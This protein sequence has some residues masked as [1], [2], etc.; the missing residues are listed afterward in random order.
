MKADVLALLSGVLYSVCAVCLVRVEEVPSPV[1][2]VLL[3]FCRSVLL[4]YVIFLL[5]CY[6]LPAPLFT[7]KEFISFHVLFGS[8]NTRCSFRQQKLNLRTIH[9]LVSDVQ[10]A[11]HVFI[12]RWS[13]LSCHG[14]GIICM[15]GYCE[16]LYWS[17]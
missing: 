3:L 17:K 4:I 12:C 8:C 16:R 1:L 14:D 15:F 5:R 10:S 13:F 9:A 6:H 2:P 7:V 11:R